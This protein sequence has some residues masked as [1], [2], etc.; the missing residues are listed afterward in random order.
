MFYRTSI[1]ENWLSKAS[2]GSL[3]YRASIFENGLSKA[4]KG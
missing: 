2:E 1:F 4:S 3:F